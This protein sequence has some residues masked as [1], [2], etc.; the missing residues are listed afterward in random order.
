MTTA[1][2]PAVVGAGP[3]GIRAA[4]ALVAH[5][6]RP[7]IVDEG[8]TSGGQVY[9]RQPG[10]FRRVASALYGFE[11]ARAQSVHAAMQVLASQAD[12]RPRR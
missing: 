10:N 1:M 9:R 6:L 3:A 12:Y 11:A 7:V 5:G 2:Q 4:Q 8:A